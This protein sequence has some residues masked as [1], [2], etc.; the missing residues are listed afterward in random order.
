MTTSE[1]AIHATVVAE[2]PGTF[3]GST[4]GPRKET[5]GPQEK[6]R[7]EVAEGL[8][9]NTDVETQGSPVVPVPAVVAAKTGHPAGVAVAPGGEQIPGRAVQA[10]PLVR[11]R[12]AGCGLEEDAREG[13]WLDKVILRVGARVP[14]G[15]L[16]RGRFAKVS[17]PVAVDDVHE[18]LR[19]WRMTMTGT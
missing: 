9:G 2:K 11:R 15:R 16:H 19:T 5:E 8:A 17:F 7:V 18:C 6:Q 4:Y 14:W 12:K 1:G 10:L 3:P 13:V